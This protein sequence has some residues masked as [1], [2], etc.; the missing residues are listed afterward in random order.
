MAAEKCFACDRIIKGKPR[1]ADTRDGQVV[2]VGYGC[3]K[4][5][6]AAGERGYKPYKG[7]PALYPMKETP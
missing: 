3:L 7:G 4:R 5:I 1:M 6:V 2:H